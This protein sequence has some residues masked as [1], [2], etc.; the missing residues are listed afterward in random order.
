MHD[1]AVLSIW[2]W[3][4]HKQR[5]ALAKQA[6]AQQGQVGSQSV[7]E[8]TGGIAEEDADSKSKEGIGEM[9]Y[10]TVHTCLKAVFLYFQ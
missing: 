3:Q 2:L 8:A 7:G 5:A 4:A 1:C 6:K 10:P 9:A